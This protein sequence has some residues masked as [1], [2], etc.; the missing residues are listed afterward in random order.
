[1]VPCSSF[2]SPVLFMS[3]SSVMP[4]AP[5][6]LNPDDAA[7]IQQGISITLA[8][9]DVRHVPSITR[10][11]GCRL[12]ADGSLLELLLV[13]SQSETLLRDVEKTGRIAV[14]FT[15]PATHRTLQIKGSDARVRKATAA[16]EELARTSQEAF[17]GEIQPLGFSRAFNDRLF[18]HAEADLCV[19]SF[20]PVDL[21]QQT[22]GPQAGTRIG[23]A[24]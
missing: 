9:R 5:A 6:L 14:V 15:Q 17:A 4:P 12:S 2:L 16:D 8:S 13:R 18:A 21:F 10:A 1:M 7:F 20:T 24:R 19:V 11:L 3:S 22:P 23:A